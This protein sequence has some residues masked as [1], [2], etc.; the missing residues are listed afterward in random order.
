MAQRTQ[1]KPA[2]F[3][4]QRSRLR[5]LRAA[6]K[7]GGHTA[8]LITNATDIRY[9]TS[10]SGEDSFALV[11]AKSLHVLSDFRFNEQ[12]DAIKPVAKIVLRSGLMPE[13]V[14]GLV[15]ELGIKSLAI[16][17]EHMTVAQKT[18][19]A[20]S[21]RPAKLVDTVGMLDALR[22]IKD[23]TEIASIKK[24]INIQQRALTQ[25]LDEI[26]PG[27]TESRIVAILEYNMKSLG[28]DGPAFGTIAAAKT[29]GAIPH[30]VAG[31]T[32]TAKNK[33][34]EE[35]RVGKECRS[36]WSPYH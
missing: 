21:L 1:T 13:T 31:K 14:K 36:R 9:L 26:G 5:K 17:A 25:T 29:N 7:K 12:L 33:R 24:A 4:P 10:F 22:V 3:V 19:Y 23:E 2:P 28:S 8:L 34:S 32:K 30:A 11:T 16:Q 27:M 6:M 35:R 20:A 18:R 15:R